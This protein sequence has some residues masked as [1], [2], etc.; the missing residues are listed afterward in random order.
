MA[1]LH[2]EKLQKIKKMEARY[3]LP[4]NWLKY[5]KTYSRVW[6]QKEG[7]W[8]IVRELAGTLE[9]K[10]IL[11]AGC[12]DGL[13]TR[14]LFDAGAGGITGVDW[15][16]NALRFARVFVSNATFIKADLRSIPLPDASFD[17][18][19]FL[20]TLEHFPPE[21]I[22]APIKELHRLLKSDGRLLL[23]VPS[24][25]LRI[26]VEEHSAHFQHFTPS[27]LQETLQDYFTPKQIQGQDY[28]AW[29]LA[30]LS[31][32]F[33]N[34]WF[35]IHPLAKFFNGYYYMRFWNRA[36][37]KRAGHLIAIFTK[38]NADL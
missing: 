32:T 3:A 14:L 12:G 15:S 36:P 5:L 7:R 35:L 4:L 11:D 19:V 27:S 38:K 20:E 22:A 2:R 6:R 17:L 24:N 28:R 23:S 26:G 31:K 8:R 9:N 33:E 18:I 16:E 30:F 34:R 25:K 13:Y 1:H 10:K 37:L 29:W 21:N